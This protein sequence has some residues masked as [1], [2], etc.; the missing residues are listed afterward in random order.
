[1]NKKFAHLNDTALSLYMHSVVNSQRD[2][3]QLLI[4]LT[5]ERLARNRAKRQTASY[6][7]VPEG[8]K[9]Q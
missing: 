4:E 7:S 8:D 5:E 1:M 2:L 6:C 3:S 9:N